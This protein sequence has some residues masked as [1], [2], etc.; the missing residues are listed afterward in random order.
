MVTA[1]VINVGCGHFF[2]YNCIVTKVKTKW[3]TPR[4]FFSCL[5]CPLCKVMMRF[6]KGS[7]LDT[8]SRE[9]FDLYKNVKEKSLLRLKYE[10]DAK[11]KKRLSN[12]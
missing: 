2:H 7:Y 9:M 1:P 8:V 12:P 11:D 4:I 10:N 6:P 3:W 5:E